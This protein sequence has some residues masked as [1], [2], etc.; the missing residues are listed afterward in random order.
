MEKP[1]GLGVWSWLRDIWVD[2]RPFLN[3]RAGPPDSSCRRRPLQTCPAL[4][5]P[6]FFGHGS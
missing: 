3:I 2:G 6:S 4:T 1:G 5:F